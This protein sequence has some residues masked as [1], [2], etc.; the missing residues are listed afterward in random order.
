MSGVGD[1]NGNGSADFLVGDSRDGWHAEE[2]RCYLYLGHDILDGVPAMIIYQSETD[3]LEPK[4][5]DDARF[6]AGMDSC[7]RGRKGRGRGNE[8][9]RW[10]S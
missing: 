3:T 8:R 5:D 2:R 4:T 1:V 9:D 7:Q 6:G 10:R